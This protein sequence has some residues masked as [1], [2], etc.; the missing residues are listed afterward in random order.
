M[1]NALE[2][3]VSITSIV[4]EILETKGIAPNQDLVSVGLDSIKA[5]NLVVRLEEQFNIMFEEDL[6]KIQHFS[7][8]DKINLRIFKKL[9]LD[10]TS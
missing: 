1:N 6:L 5:I 3:H 2:A 10:K 4:E 7:S 8:I 9:G